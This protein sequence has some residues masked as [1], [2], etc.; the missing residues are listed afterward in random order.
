MDVELC[1]PVD[2][3]P[4]AKLYSLIR[5]DDNV[6][7][8]CRICGETR[9]VCRISAQVNLNRGDHLGDRGLSVERYY[10]R[11]KII[12]CNTRTWARTRIIRMCL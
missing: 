11:R 8:I 1:S 3:H 10:K 6:D 2:R 9:D 12:G 5:K 7:W 4:S